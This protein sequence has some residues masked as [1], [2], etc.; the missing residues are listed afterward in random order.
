MNDDYRIENA[1]DY[2]G[3]YDRRVYVTCDSRVHHYYHFSVCRFTFVPSATYL[4]MFRKILWSAVHEKK[5]KPY[6]TVY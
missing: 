4:I 1:L 2:R 5:E 6:I 3:I